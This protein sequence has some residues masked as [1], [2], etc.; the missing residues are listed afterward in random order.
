[1]LHTVVTCYAIAGTL[2]WLAMH[3]AGAF[4]RFTEGLRHPN[5][6]LACLTLSVVVGWP[7]WLG[8]YLASLPR[9]YRAGKLWG[10]RR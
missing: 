8:Y 2:T 1:M 5:G 9:R 3:G 6:V 4:D 10:M 7:I